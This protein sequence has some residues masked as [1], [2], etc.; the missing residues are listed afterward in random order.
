MIFKKSGVIFIS[1]GRSVHIGN[2]R[3]IFK[4][5]D[6]VINAVVDHLTNDGKGNKAAK[7]SKSHLADTVLSFYPP[8]ATY[9]SSIRKLYR[10]QRGFHN[11]DVFGRLVKAGTEKVF[12]RIFYRNGIP[13]D[14][15][16]GKGPETLNSY[17]DENYFLQP[18]GAFFEPNCQGHLSNIPDKHIRKLNESLLFTD[19]VVNILMN[20]TVIELLFKKPARIDFVAAQENNKWSNIFQAAIDAFN[21][22]PTIG[23]CSVNFC[24]KL[25]QL[26]PEISHTTPRP[27]Q[28][29]LVWTLPSFRGQEACTLCDISN[30]YCIHFFHAALYKKIL[31]D[32]VD[33][34][35]H[36][37]TSG[38]ITKMLSADEETLKN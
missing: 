8:K 16:Y 27:D 19:D 28:K 5:T 4:D 24:D 38:L 7:S 37:L 25:K 15:F 29:F 13:I 32:D 14:S 10:E 9:T 2:K 12:R 17:N 36:T 18:L 33:I 31:D 3:L 1:P 30:Q 23:N 20:P 26:F 35:G 21:E 11:I 6:G 22:S 34:P